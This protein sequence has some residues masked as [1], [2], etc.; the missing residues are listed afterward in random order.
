MN[1][2]AA[3]PFDG[4][5][6]IHVSSMTMM[7]QHAEANNVLKKHKMVREYQEKVAAGEIEHIEPPRKPRAKPAAKKKKAPVTAEGITVHK[8]EP[9]FDSHEINMAAQT[10][11]M[12]QVV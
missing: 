1:G 8:Q 5:P 12:M 11:E 10:L 7:C 6:F 2:M 3:V 9:I 4:V